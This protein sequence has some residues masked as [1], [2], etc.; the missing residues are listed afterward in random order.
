M[1]TSQIS[2]IRRW[3]WFFPF[4][5]FPS[6]ENELKGFEFK[7]S[8]LQKFIADYFHKIFLKECL[9]FY[10]VKIKRSKVFIVIYTQYFFFSFLSLT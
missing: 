6:D 9:D 3:L 4:S 5:C 8:N 2:K 7:V 10:F 1:F